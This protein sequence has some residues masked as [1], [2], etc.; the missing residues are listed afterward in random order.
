MGDR[1]EAARGWSPGLVGMV[2]AAAAVVALAGLKASASIVGPTMLALLLTI[3]VSPLRA[4]LERRRAPF[5]LCV[6]VPL[7][8]VIVMLLALG[9]G[10]ALS[11]AQLAT[12]LPTYSTQLTGL[13]HGVTEELARHGVDEAK[14]QTTLSKLDPGQLFTFIQGFLN[15]LLS[16]SSAIVLIVLMLVGMCLDATGTVRTLERI[17]P[18]QPELVD[19]L[20]RFAR[21][22]TRYLVVST[23]FGAIV[24]ALDVVVLY[25]FDVPVPL[26]WGLLAF[27]TNYIPNIGFVIGLAP[28]ALLGLLEGGW[29]A[30]VWIIV[31]YCVIN[32]VLQS[33]VQP[34]FLG[35]AV[36][37]SF[38]LVSLSLLLWAWVLGPLGAILAVPLSSLA[39]ALLVDADPTKKWLTGLLGPAVDGPDP[40]LDADG[41]PVRR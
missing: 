40:R 1:G 4:R 28:P 23:V 6:A 19:A 37:L 20:R 12:L 35:N 41:R 3:A 7:V 30:M 14:L 13:L 25:V 36:G 24:A 2:G 29:T 33:L 34:K 39:K 21:D 38:T 10:L 27:L 11:V 17:R 22:T 9:A 8:T 15:G 18:Q 5:W 26:L 31:A 16:A 32:F